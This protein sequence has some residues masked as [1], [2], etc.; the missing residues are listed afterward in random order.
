MQCWCHGQKHT[1]A[2]QAGSHTHNEAFLSSGCI[3]HR[4]PCLFRVVLHKG[5]G[6]LNTALT[7]T[8]AAFVGRNLHACA[9]TH[10][11]TH[12]LQMRAYGHDTGAKKSCPSLLWRECIHMHACLQT[13]YGVKAKY[14]TFGFCLGMC[15]H[16][17]TQNMM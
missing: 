15:M 11:H 4:H 8:A 5:H 3:S 16:A 14:N 10:I 7:T 17:C 1:T 2:I 9:H 6:A 12:T 13:I